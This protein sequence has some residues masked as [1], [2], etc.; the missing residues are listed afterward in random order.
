MEEISNLVNYYV[1]IILTF[2][3]TIHWIVI[4]QIVHIIELFI[5]DM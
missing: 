4:K 1:L 2:I 5:R 3:I